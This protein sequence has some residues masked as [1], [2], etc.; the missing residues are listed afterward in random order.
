MPGPGSMRQPASV[1]CWRIA[2]ATSNLWIACAVIV[3]IGLASWWRAGTPGAHAVNEITLHDGDK[4]FL[5]EL[6]RGRGLN[7]PMPKLAFWEGVDAFGKVMSV[8]CG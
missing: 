2:S 3:F 1:R 8:C 7:C 6:I 5:G 4:K